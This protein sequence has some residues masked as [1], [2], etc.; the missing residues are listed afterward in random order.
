MMSDRNGDSAGTAGAGG[1]PPRP[2]TALSRRVALRV[3][4]AA[5]AGIAATAAGCDSGSDGDRGSGGDGGDGGR[6][7]NRPPPAP[8]ASPYP[9]AG[10]SLAGG[11]P[12]EIDHGRRD[13]PEVALTF[14]GQGDP[15]LARRLLEE[16]E[17]GGARATV[18]VVGSWTEEQPA[19]VTRILDGGHE[20]GNHTQRHLA[21]AELDPAQVFAEISECAARLRRLTGSVGS[22]FRPSQTQFSTPTIR[23]Q[24]AR[25]G[26]PTCLS[27][28]LDS[29]DS[30]DPGPAAVAGTTLRSVRNGSIVSLHFGH[31]GTVAAVPEILDGL[32][33]RGL[34]AVTVTDLM[35]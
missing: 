24:A 8:A 29:L 15:A 21:L 17:R 14:H 25:A 10:P 28:D 7:P 18:L 3:S 11:L 30:T 32:R 35:A 19:M 26:Y 23:A 34:R 16:L 6:R 9:S 27:Y 5:V 13:R 20:I 12:A 31:A 33:Q 22:W 1:P 2:E 4:L